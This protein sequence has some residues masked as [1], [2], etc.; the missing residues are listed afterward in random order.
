MNWLCFR[1]SAKLGFART[2]QI[3]AAEFELKKEEKNPIISIQLRKKYLKAASTI[4][5]LAIFLLIDTPKFHPVLVCPRLAGFSLPP[6][7]T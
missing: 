6:Y 5:D 4:K 2:N 1:V 3:A 7:V